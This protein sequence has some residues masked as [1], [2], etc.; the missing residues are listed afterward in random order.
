M[1]FKD[2][3]HHWL[4]HWQR[5]KLSWFMKVENQWFSEEAGGEKRIGWRENN[6]QLCRLKWCGDCPTYF[7]LLSFL[8]TG[9]ADSL[10][11]KEEQG[12][13]GKERTEGNRTFQEFRELDMRSSDNLVFAQFL[14]FLLNGYFYFTNF[15][16]LFKQIWIYFLAMLFNVT[17]CTPFLTQVHSIPLSPSSQ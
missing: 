9:S 11:R 10:W 12:V 15:G 3:S 17:L 14:V 7:L 5:H 4:L 1:T 8:N 2:G 16:I 13:N 6:E